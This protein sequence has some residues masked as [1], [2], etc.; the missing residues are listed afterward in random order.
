MDWKFLV[1][2]LGIPA[3]I[4]LG[5]WVWSHT[6]GKKEKKQENRSVLDDIVENFVYE[7]LD[8]YP[9][10]VDVETYLKNSRGY[11]EKYIWTVAQ[12]RGIPRNKATELLFNAA[13]ER[14]TKLLGQEIAELKKTNEQRKHELEV[15][16]K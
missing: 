11:I 7:M 6:L 16:R 1:E 2:K 14:G 9:L 8:K 4:T 10:N 5:T 3:A 15:T 13:L 12:K